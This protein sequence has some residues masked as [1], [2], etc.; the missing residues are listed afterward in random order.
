MQPRVVMNTGKHETINLKHFEIVF[1]F[2]KL[3]IW[4]M[5]MNFADNNVTLQYKKI[6]G[7]L[8]SKKLRA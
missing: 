5:K 7:A 2:L 3:I 8:I 1:P 4:L 6:H